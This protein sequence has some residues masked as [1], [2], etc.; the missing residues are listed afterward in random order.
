MMTKMFLALL[1]ILTLLV[2]CANAESIFPT[3]VKP[4]EKKAVIPLVSDYISTPMISWEDVGYC[5]ILKYEEPLLTEEVEAY[6]AAVSS[7]GSFSLVSQAVNDRRKEAQVYTMLS[8]FAYDGPGYVSTISP[9][10]ILFSDN[11]WTEGSA[12]TACNLTLYVVWNS[13]IPVCTI[14]VYKAEELTYDSSEAERVSQ[15]KKSNDSSLDPLG[16]L[17]KS[18]DEDCPS[19]YGLGICSKCLG[20]GECGYCFGRGGEYCDHCI[21]GRCINC[22][23]TGE[24]YSS[25]GLDVKK[26]R[27]SYCNGG[28]CKYCG[29]TGEKKCGICHGTGHCSLCNGSGKC[30]ACNGTGKR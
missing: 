13:Q 30:K 4:E 10:I 12:Q 25:F 8:N 21:G 26:V 19:C 23:G 6:I 16:G 3:L 11:V 15:V 5:Y 17:D 28:R 24:V 14:S 29:G 9:S 1:L 18:I 7:T 20:D 22:G 2:P 27:C